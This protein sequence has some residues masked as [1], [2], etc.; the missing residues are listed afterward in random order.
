MQSCR[1]IISQVKISTIFWIGSRTTYM[2]WQRLDF[3][4]IFTPEL[5]TLNKREEINNHCRHKVNSLLDNTWEISPVFQKLSLILICYVTNMSICYLVV[6]VWLRSEGRILT[7]M[8]QICTR[9]NATTLIFSNVL[10]IYI[11]MYCRI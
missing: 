5:G 3:H 10:Y 11:Y 6:N 8:K 7:F 4:L 1:L 9:I 2:A